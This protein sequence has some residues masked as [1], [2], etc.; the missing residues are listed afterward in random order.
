[1]FV[2]FGYATPPDWTSTPFIIAW[3]VEFLILFFLY[4]RY[5]IKKRLAWSQ[6]ILI[7]VLADLLYLLAITIL[8]YVLVAIQ[9]CTALSECSFF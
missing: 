6:V 2:E 8:I 5:R 7:F 4:R 3:F 9:I 1:M